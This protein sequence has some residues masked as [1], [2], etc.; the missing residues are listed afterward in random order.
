MSAE[1]C[2]HK[3]QEEHSDTITSDFRPIF[4]S[5]MYLLEDFTSL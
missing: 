5:V 2:E 4:F 1:H 3:A